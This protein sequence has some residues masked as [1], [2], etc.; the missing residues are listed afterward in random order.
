MPQ[1]YR[2]HAEH[3]L[4]SMK[5]RRV[6]CGSDSSGGGQV[7][8]SEQPRSEVQRIFG[9]AASAYAVSAVHAS[10]R[11]LAALVEAAQLTGNER[12][13]DIGCG[14][15]HTA[16][17][18][19]PKAASVVAL[20]VT[21]E[22][23]DVAA[24]LAQQRGVT[25]ISFRLADVAALPFPDASFDVVTSR[26][27]AHH[28]EDPARAIQEAA[29][30]LRPGG[31]LLLADTIAPEI[32]ALDTF[33]NAAELL[34]DGSHI[35]NWRISEWQRMCVAAGLTSEVIFEM[36]IDLD[37]ENWVQRLQTPPDNVIAIKTLFRAATPAATSFFD[38]RTGDTPESSPWGWHIPMAIIR[39]NR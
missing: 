26:F 31:R 34:R 10:G 25:N 30:V 23:L 4:D 24:H 38:L 28:Y 36:M 9:A 32:P 6:R 8:T 21:Q 14:A 18:V 35:R 22:M 20:D 39:A 17:A 15:G 2:S 33:Y 16:L 27:S 3:I 19:A 13:L 12:V 29:R 1:S 5:H 7:T 11:D 37:G